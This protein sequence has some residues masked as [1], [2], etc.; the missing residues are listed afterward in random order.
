MRLNNRRYTRVK[1][2]YY[3]HNAYMDNELLIKGNSGKKVENLQEKLLKLSGIFPNL[4]VVVIDGY[5]G[6]QTKKAVEIFQEINSIPVTGQVDSLTLEKINYYLKN[7]INLIDEKI[8][9]DDIDMSDNVV[10]LGSKGKYVS[11]LQI[12]LNIAHNMLPNLDKVKVNGIF[13]ENTKQAVLKFQKEYG[14]DTDGIVGAVT[15]DALLD[16]AENGINGK[17]E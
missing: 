4:P 16:T 1:N 17:D 9:Y 10:K 12:L 11:D 2:S 13:D 14:I 8:N 5:Y 15:W 3:I 7:R 6:E